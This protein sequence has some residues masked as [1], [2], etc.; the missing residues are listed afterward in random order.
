MQQVTLGGVQ[1]GRIGFGAMGMSAYY[2]GAREDDEQS[3]RTIRRAIDLGVTL[4]D[5]AEIYGPYLNEEL[6]GR[7]L[8]GRRDEVVLAAWEG[9][10]LLRR[11]PSGK[12][13]K[14]R[15]GSGNQES[16]PFKG[17]SEVKRGRVGKARHYLA[18]IEPWHGSQVVVYTSPETGDV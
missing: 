10:F 1:V 6:V 14:V 9:V 5:T 4:I 17:A 2:T 12:W 8:A 11:D 7:A 18:T 16:K 3:V 15:I 13:S